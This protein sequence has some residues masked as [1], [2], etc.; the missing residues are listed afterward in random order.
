MIQI[1]DCIRTCPALSPPKPQSRPY[2]R[3]LANLLLL[4]GQS[5]ILFYIEDIGILIKLIGGVLII[6]SLVPLKLWDMI[7]IVCAFNILDMSKLIHNIL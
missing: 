1:R 3:Y 5:F 4:L 2:V 7:I 6:Y